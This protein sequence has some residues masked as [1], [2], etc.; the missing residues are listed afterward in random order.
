MVSEWEFI[1]LKL[2]NNKGKKKHGA[3]FLNE[4]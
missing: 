4:I 2:E 1:H 3:D